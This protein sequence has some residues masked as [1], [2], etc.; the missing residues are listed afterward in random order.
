MLNR[1]SS[2]PCPLCRIPVTKNGI[3]PLPMKNACPT[4][5]NK[6]HC[7]WHKS[8]KLVTLVKE[9]KAIERCRMGLGSYEGLESVG[10]TVV[11][12]QWTRYLDIIESALR[13]NGLSYFRLDGRLSSKERS[14][15]LS[16][17]RLDQPDTAVGS[18]DILLVSL[19]AGGVGLNL[20]TASQVFIVDP[21]WNPA[22]SYEWKY[23]ERYILDV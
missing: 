3:V 23:F 2:V 9:L 20:T 18:A 22:V 21:W 13:D 16:D 12:S 1:R 8:S 11:F 17:F 19:K 15:T 4:S 7:V 14:K 6:G 10:K 5:D